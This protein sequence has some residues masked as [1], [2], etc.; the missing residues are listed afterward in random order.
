MIASATRI[1][2]TNGRSDHEVV[3]TPITANVEA[4]LNVN[5]YKLGKSRNH[6]L[7]EHSCI[8]EYLQVEIAF[9]VGMILAVNDR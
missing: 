1:A 4:S 6:D 3:Q 2:I 7:N 9:T 5:A 8:S